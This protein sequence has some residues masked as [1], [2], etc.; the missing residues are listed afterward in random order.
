MVI[1][2][3]FLQRCDANDPMTAAL[4]L[5]KYANGEKSYGTKIQQIIEENG[6][7]KYDKLAK[8]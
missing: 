8:K 7:T 5:S 2:C 3:Y 4:E 6:L 1:N